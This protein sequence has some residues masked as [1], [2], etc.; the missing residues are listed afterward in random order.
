MRKMRTEGFTIAE[1]LVV[2]AIVGILTTISIPVFA[3]QKKKAVVAA[4]KDNIRVAKSVAMAEIYG[5][6][7]ESAFLAAG[8]DPVYLVYNVK[9]GQ[10]DKVVTGVGEGNRDGEKAYKQAAANQVADT[11]V[12]YIGPKDVKKGNMIQT[13]PYY[14]D[15]DNVGVRG[16]N[17]FG[18]ECGSQNI[19]IK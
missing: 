4:N 2:V 1:L 7:A 13:A 11:V 6:K 19:T 15:N 17:F 18:P 3:A 8:D 14:D 9:T 5:G 12:V 10:I 16:N